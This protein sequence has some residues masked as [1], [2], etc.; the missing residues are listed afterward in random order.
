[1]IATLSC[2]TTGGRMAVLGP[3]AD[4]Q[5]GKNA[6]ENGHHLRAIEMLDAFE[7]RHP[8]SRFVDDALFY[9]GLAHEANNEQILARQAFERLLAAFPR[10]EY[11]EQGYF[12]I[13]HTWYRSKRGPELDPEPAHEALTAFRSYNVRYPEGQFIQQAND[14]IQEI[15]YLLAEKDY[16][17]GQTYLKIKRYEAARRYFQKSLDRVE[18]APC[19]AK[20]LAGIARSYEKEKNWSAARQTYKDLESLLAVD[21][22][23]F[24]D[25]EKLT[26]RL[27]DK[28]ASLP[29]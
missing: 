25:G 12:E 11:A 28:L 18:N 24:E 1:M 2:S 23:S 21:P 19:R 6:Y 3:E 17:N 16:R 7:F 27:N 10:S 5:K 15:L 26:Q 29:Q 22:A 9:L 13:A 20:A 14:S 4:F 8:G